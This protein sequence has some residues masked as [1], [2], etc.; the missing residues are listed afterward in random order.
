[1]SRIFRAQHITTHTTRAA[2]D[3]RAPS[4][5]GSREPSEL[6]APDTLRFARVSATRRSTTWSRRGACASTAGW[7]PESVITAILPHRVCLVVPF[8]FLRGLG[9]LILGEGSTRPKWRGQHERG[10]LPAVH[11]KRMASVLLR[12]GVAKELATYE[13]ARGPGG[14]PIPYTHRLPIMNYWRWVPNHGT[15]SKPAQ[16]PTPIER[17][18]PPA[19]KPTETRGDAGTSSRS[20]ASL[21]SERISR[22]LEPNPASL[23]YR[24]CR[25]G[26]APQL[27]SS[28]SL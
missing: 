2:S 10:S 15:Q 14:P 21:V 13:V 20:Y 3:A 28:S 26:P 7:D 22:K 25:V 6:P 24:P 4:C 27:M 16:N 23:A 12:G 1:M 11:R 18:N 19:A 5:P 8:C 9:C 17:R